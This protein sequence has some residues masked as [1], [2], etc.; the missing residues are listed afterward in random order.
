MNQSRSFDQKA[1][2]LDPYN[3]QQSKD[4]QACVCRTSTGHPFTLGSSLWLAWAKCS[5]CLKQ[6]G[7]V[8]P[9]NVRT[10]DLAI[11]HFCSSAEPYAF[12]FITE[13]QDFLLAQW[14]GVT[15]TPVFSGPITTLYPALQPLWSTKPPLANIA[16]GASTVDYGYGAL[17]GQTPIMASFTTTTTET[18][19]PYSVEMITGSSVVSW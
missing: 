13:L 15:P 9:E 5:Y 18:N 12:L 1:P 7:H 4:F 16:F 6:F 2:W 8:I 17:N 14:P 19:S 10:E 3:T 11:Y